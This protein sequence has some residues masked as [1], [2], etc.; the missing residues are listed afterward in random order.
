MF[1]YY[2]MVHVFQINLDI[3]ECDLGMYNCE[4]HCVNNNGSYHCKCNDG[5]LISNGFLCK[6]MTYDV[7]LT[8]VFIDIDECANG[9]N[10]CDQECINTV[11]SF[12][13]ECQLG[14]NLNSSDNSSCYGM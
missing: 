12:Y 11:G 7:L 4:Q 8:L 13:C 2:F 1:R 3:N 10:N 6:G 9:I 5:Y 14:F